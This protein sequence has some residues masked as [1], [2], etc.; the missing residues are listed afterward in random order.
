M[1][2]S[3]GKIAVVIGGGNGI[4]EACCELMASRGWKVV[5]ADFDIEG[6]RNVAERIGSTAYQIDVR[7]HKAVEELAA[8]I[9][10]D[11]GPV[12]ALA[13][14]AGVVQDRYRPEDFPMDQY[15]NILAVNIEGTFNCCRAFG[16]RMAKRGK[17]SIVAIA[18]STAYVGH[19]LYAYGPSKAAV[20]NL[21]FALAGEWGHAGVRVNSISPGPTMV[22]RQLKRPPGRYAPDAEKHLALGRRLQPVEIAEGVE[23]LASDRASAITGIDLPMDAGQWA[24]SGWGF[25]GG[26]PSPEDGKGVLLPR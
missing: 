6:A 9:E 2:G 12:A 10:R 4:G 11:I 19:Q 16:P 17:G 3:E 13:V 23:F 1:E 26:V 21:V 15:R 8:T 22:K 18:S 24:G 5:V 25:F 7:D 20:I 14:P